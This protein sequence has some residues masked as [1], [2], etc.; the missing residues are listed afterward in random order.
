MAAED[1]FDLGRHEALIERLSGDVADVKASL[2]RIETTL[3]E[4]R[5]ERRMAMYL[6]GTV[7]GGV[8]ALLG[9]AARRLH[10]MP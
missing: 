8:A 3:A 5:G 2:G 10:L 6:A 9:V 4:K 7:G 1:S